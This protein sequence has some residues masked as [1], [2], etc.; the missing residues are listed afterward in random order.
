VDTAKLNLPAL[1][2]RMLER[3]VAAVRADGRFEALL[4]TGSLAYGGFD[5][6]SD[7]DFVIVVRAD[8]HTSAMAGR[9]AFAAHL[10]SLLA[11]FS[12]E[13]VGE[14]RLLICLFGPPLLHVDLKFITA[15]DLG[16][17]SERPVVLWARN[18]GALERPLAGMTVSGHGRDA[19]WYE[20]RAWVWLHYVAT[21]LL[22]GEHFEA[23]GGLDFF[24][25]QVLGAMLQRNAGRRARCVRR[26]EDVDGAKALLAPTLPS[27]GQRS[28]AEALKRSAALYVEL[29]A[30]EMPPSPVKG[31]PGLLLDFIDGKQSR[32]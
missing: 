13:H 23:I 17:L 10:G 14:P 18:A 3:V 20:D 32:A 30:A 27:T 31:M 22:R 4:G 2:A 28:I 29:R 1:H 5:Q 6:H 9:E 15:T 7:L 21:K 11:A 19:Q 24:R 12:G 16:T 25:D 8:D 26:I